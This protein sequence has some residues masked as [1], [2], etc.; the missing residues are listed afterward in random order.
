MQ[1][2]VDNRFEDAAKGALGEEGY[3][4]FGEVERSLEGL[5]DVVWVSGSREFAPSSF[6][7]FPA[8]VVMHGA[9]DVDRFVFR[10]RQCWGC[11]DKWTF[12]NRSCM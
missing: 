11:F 4:H 5:V 6:P 7:S 3:R 12:A 2:K 8:P 10:D 1:L 9:A